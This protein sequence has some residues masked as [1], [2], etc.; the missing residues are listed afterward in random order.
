MLG[1]RRRSTAL[2][3]H[4][5]GICCTAATECWHSSVA[6]PPGRIQPH[7]PHHPRPT[8]L[9]R[10]PGHL[11]PPPLRSQRRPYNGAA[12]ATDCVS[13]EGSAEATVWHGERTID[14]SS[15]RRHD[16]A[17][18]AGARMLPQSDATVAQMHASCTPGSSCTRVRFRARCSEHA[19]ESARVAHPALAG[20]LHVPT[21]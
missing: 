17:Q 15:P 21:M 20:M 4:P 8:A 10:S 2:A 18:L 14:V 6:R 16:A 7:P 13:R 5:G 9:T 19:A 12:T 11:R 1:G 3:T